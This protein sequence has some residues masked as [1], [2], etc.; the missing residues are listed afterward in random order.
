MF[1]IAC[2]CGTIAASAQ[3]V[4]QFRD[5]LSGQWVVFDS[6][7]SSSAAPCTIV[8]QTNVETTQTL[9]ESASRPT[10]N[11]Q[12]CIAPLSSTAT[13]DIEQGQLVMYSAEN[14]VIA[15][16]GGSQL[17]VTGDLESSFDS[18]VLERATGD[19]YQKR[20]S[21]AL[22]NYR[23]IFLGYTDECADQ[24]AL[25][26]PRT[27][28]DGGTVAQITILTRLNVRDQPRRNATVL[29]TLDQNAC[30]SV[31]YCTTASDGIWC[32]A[33]FGETSGWVAKTA[34]RQEEWPVTTFVSGCE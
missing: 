15:R 28:T 6:A 14:Q 16:L 7:F 30:I 17:R 20:F 23:C 21:Q 1:L 9:Q 22:Q 19:P 11:T 26:A 10:A 4:Q 29:G 12:N 8:L 34:I 32:R 13:W 25:A 27:L 5:A 24:T 2:L 18:V 33:S 3:S 31:N